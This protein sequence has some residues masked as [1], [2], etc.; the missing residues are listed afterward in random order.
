[1]VRRPAGNPSVNSVPSV[2]N[3][4]LYFVSFLSS[5]FN[6]FVVSLWLVTRFILPKRPQRGIVQMRQT[7]EAVHG[8]TVAGE[9]EIGN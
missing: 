7:V 6:L 3:S 1:V 8:Q 9:D 2:A 4:S 5:W